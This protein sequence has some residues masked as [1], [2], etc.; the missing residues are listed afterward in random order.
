VNIPDARA[1]LYDAAIKL[2]ECNYSSV[3]PE[4]DGLERAA[5][6]YTLAWLEEHHKDDLRHAI[7]MLSSL[8]AGVGSTPVEAP[9]S[10]STPAAVQAH[11]HLQQGENTVPSQANPKTGL[12]IF[13]CGCS[14]QK[15]LA[16]RCDLWELVAVPR[17]DVPA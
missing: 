7:A 9:T 3:R 13:P 1:A 6:N 4:L 14:R 12:A 15:V 10:P 17:H 8:G 11:P 5:R 16:G 2:A